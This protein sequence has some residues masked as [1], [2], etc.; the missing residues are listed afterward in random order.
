MP[1]F[2]SL[3]YRLK[4][5]SLRY[6]LNKSKRAS[7]GESKLKNVYDLIPDESVSTRCSLK[8][9]FL[10]S[11][12]DLPQKYAFTSPGA[13]SSPDGKGRAV[14]A[15]RFKEQLEALKSEC[16]L[17]TKV[18]SLP[19]SN[20][21]EWVR[22]KGKV[23]KPSQNAVMGNTTATAA[24]NNLKKL[25]PSLKKFLPDTGHWM[26]LIGFSLSGSECPQDKGNLVAG[27]V[28]GNFD[29]IIF[30]NLV[31]YLCNNA[32]SFNLDLNKSSYKVSAKCL[33]NVAV[34]FCCRLNLV[35][36]NGVEKKITCNIDPQK[37]KPT[38]TAAAES[39]QEEVNK[40]VSDFISANY[41]KKHVLDN[42]ENLHKNIATSSQFKL[43]AASVCVTPPKRQRLS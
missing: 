4:F 26:H 17:V 11:S 22:I 30:E 2:N 14:V 39:Q 33:E 15:Y 25:E 41:Y 42:Q 7:N 23:R 29:H 37:L 40:L 13:T 38:D 1:K 21:G 18:Q 19:L 32:K 20:L 3:R 10:D 35:L 12:A 36:N 31:V 9:E 34:K 16:Q 6:R 28:H 43:S 5:N 24:I 8:F 27:S